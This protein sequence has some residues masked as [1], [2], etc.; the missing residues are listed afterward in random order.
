[1]TGARLADL[2]IIPLRTPLAGISIYALPV[3]DQL[4]DVGTALA[5]LSVDERLRYRRL[6][7]PA[8]RARL[9][10]GRL[11]LRLLLAA[12]LHCQTREVCI[13]YELCGRPFAVGVNWRFSISHSGDWVALALHPRAALGLD[14]EAPRI[15]R[16]PARILLRL[17]E[18]PDIATASGDLNAVALRRWTLAEACLK[19]TGYGLGKLRELNLHAV[20]DGRA[21]RLLPPLRAVNFAFAPNPQYHAAVAMMSDHAGVP[22]DW[23]RPDAGQHNL[24]HG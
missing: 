22:V 1:M 23:Q 15:L 17:G 11:A 21:G 24:P 5:A 14:I 2:I 7:S 20:A 12:R 10:F 9:L 13:A 16:R 4:L 3:R 19:A 18:D 6:R 8:D